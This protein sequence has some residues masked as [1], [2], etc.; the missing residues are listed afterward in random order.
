M[1][2][3]DVH[4]HKLRDQL[5]AK[6]SVSIYNLSQSEVRD[7]FD[8]SVEN[9]YY[10]CA[11]H[12]WDVGKSVI[13]IEDIRKLASEHEKVVAIGECGLDKLTDVPM[14]KQIS[15]FERHVV[16]SEELEM[17][18]IIH[19]VK[20]WDELLR[21]YKKYKPKQVWVLHGFR[22]GASQADQLMKFG[23]YF[24]L[25]EHFNEETLKLIYPDR[26][27]IE[28]DESCINIHSAYG[29]I[30]SVLSYKKED[31]LFNVNQNVNEVFNLWV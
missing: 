19:C 23:F 3:Y 15:A 31:I 7:G 12:P 10:S 5:S 27:L 24:S 9:Q 8:M 1:I 22:G 4:T 13:S 28:T 18:L 11:I 26:L 14:Q 17:P 30:C 6:D 21:I 16:L 29:R 25:G 2:Y 20:A